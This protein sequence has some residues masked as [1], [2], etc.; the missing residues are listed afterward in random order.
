MSKTENYRI[1][2]IGDIHGSLE[3]LRDMQD[4]IATDLR[5]NPH[6]NPLVIYLGDY[7]DRGPECRAV[8]EN[9]IAVKSATLPAK[10]LYGNHDNYVPLFLE[11]PESMHERKYHWLHPA[12]GGDKTLASYGIDGAVLENATAVSAAFA[13]ALP[14]EHL[15]FVKTCEL[16]ISIG[17]Y[18]FVHAGVHPDRPLN[19]QAFDDAIWIREPFLSSKADFGAVVVHGHTVVKNVENHGNRIAVDT[20]AVFG[21]YL[22]CLVLQ[23][24]HQWLLTDGGR[25]DCPIGH[26]I[27]P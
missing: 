26:G 14:S 1:Y 19:D 25:V 3:Q 27:D 16:S 11:N 18:H 7:M 13:K 17:G 8:L 10:F 20:G 9:L 5:T 21:K 15:G 23:D 24:D 12:M 4:R 2:A 22:S 6:P